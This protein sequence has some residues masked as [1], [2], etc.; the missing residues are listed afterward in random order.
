MRRQKK[1]KTYT[2][3][4]VHHISYFPR[5]LVNVSTY[6]IRFSIHTRDKLIKLMKTQFNVGRMPSSFELRH[7]KLNTQDNVCV[8]EEQNT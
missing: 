7:V 1:G 8:I 6:Q 2:C 5:V 4:Y 3:I